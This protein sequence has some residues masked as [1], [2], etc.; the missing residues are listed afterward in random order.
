MIPAANSVWAPE[1]WQLIRIVASW[2]P[3]DVG[4]FIS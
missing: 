4:I 2:F 3:I 1:A